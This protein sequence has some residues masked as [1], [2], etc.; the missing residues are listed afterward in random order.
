MLVELKMGLA[1]YF[2]LRHDREWLITLEG[3]IM[4]RRKARPAAMASAIVMADLMG[5]MHHDADV[6][7]ERGDSEN[8]QLVWTYGRDPL[9]ARRPVGAASSHIRQIQRATDIAA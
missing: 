1:R 4:A 5:S 8:L 6:M 7:T 2:V 3:R 9:P